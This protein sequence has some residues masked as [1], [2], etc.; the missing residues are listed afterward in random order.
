MCVCKHVYARERLRDRQTDRQT[1]RGRMSSEDYILL[2]HIPQS[3]C[4]ILLVSFQS[5]CFLFFCF[6]L[7]VSIRLSKIH[8]HSPFTQPIL[9]LLF[10][11]PLHALPY[12]VPQISFSPSSVVL[13][14][15]LFCVTCV[16]VLCYLWRC[17]VLPVTCVALPVAVCCVTCGGVLCYL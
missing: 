1:D 10:F 4:T 5:L 3:R 17:V 13:P 9:S 2:S 6:F 14:V 8:P 11:L 12:S 7:T 15:A 16:G